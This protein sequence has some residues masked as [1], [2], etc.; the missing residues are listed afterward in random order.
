ME[1]RMEGIEQGTERTI[2][3]TISILRSLG[4]TDEEIVEKIVENSSISEE[5]AERYV[6]GE[7]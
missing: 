5:N 1:G 4:M 2:L 3:M 6:Y 7:E